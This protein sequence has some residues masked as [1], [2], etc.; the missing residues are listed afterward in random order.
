LTG[1]KMNGIAFAVIR[2]DPP[3]VIVARSVPV[4][5]RLL[6]IKIAKSFKPEDVDVLEKL[7]RALVEE[8]F[9]EALKLWIDATG[10]GVDV[11]PDE[12]LYEGTPLDGERFLLE[13]QRLPLF[14]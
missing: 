12:E 10:I 9:G 3:E 11:Y 5:E 13:L 2:Q 7:R 6:A 4:L 14:R 8:Q 1:V